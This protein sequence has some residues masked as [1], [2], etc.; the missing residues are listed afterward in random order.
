MSELGL[1][2]LSCQTISACLNNTYL[3]IM[4][5]YYYFNTMFAQ[6][7]YIG[8]VSDN[9]VIIDQEPRG[10]WVAGKVTNF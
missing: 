8:F 7:F 6:I 1:P 5:F 9:N 4:Q 2:L 3:I 10:V